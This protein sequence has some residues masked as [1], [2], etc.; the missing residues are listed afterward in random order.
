MARRAVAHLEMGRAAADAAALAVE[1]LE[2]LTGSE[3][4]V[5]VAD[6]SGGVGEAYNSAAMQTAVASDD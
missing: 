2:D 6:N 5:I 1:E 4:G 3:A